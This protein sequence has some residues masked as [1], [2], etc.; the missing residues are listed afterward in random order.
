M[1]FVIIFRS[2]PSKGHAD[3]TLVIKGKVCKILIFFLF[4]ILIVSCIFDVSTAFFWYLT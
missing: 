3:G 1:Y 2:T 4:Y